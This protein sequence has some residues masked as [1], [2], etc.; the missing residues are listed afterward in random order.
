MNKRRFVFGLLAL[1]AGCATAPENSARSGALPDPRLAGTFQSDKAATL[2]DLRS[3]GAYTAQKLGDMENLFGKLR[4]SYSKHFLFSEFEGQTNQRQY[5]IVTDKP[6]YLIIETIAPLRSNPV[7]Y[8]LTFTPDGYWL[9]EGALPPGFREKF[10]RVVNPPSV[11]PVPAQ[12]VP[13]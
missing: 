7:R 8:R 13:R 3:T 9:S 10:T 4:V 5:T 12:P 2:A 1:A 6:E 11:T